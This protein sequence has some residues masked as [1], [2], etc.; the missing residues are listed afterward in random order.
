MNSSL[1]LKKNVVC[2]F[3]SYFEISFLVHFNNCFCV[4]FTYTYQKTQTYEQNLT[5]NNFSFNNKQYIQTEGTAIGS[6][7]ARNYACI[8]M[9]GIWNVFFWNSA[10]YNPLFYVRYI[11]DI[12]GIWSGTE[13]DLLHFHKMANGIHSNIQLDLRFSK[14]SIEF[15]DLNIAV[16]EGFFLPTCTVNPLTNTCT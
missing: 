11:D 13:A 14:S 3:K 2:C 4:F 12:F 7:L 16:E 15:Q 5:I 10:T 9:W 1:L 8:Y 6:K